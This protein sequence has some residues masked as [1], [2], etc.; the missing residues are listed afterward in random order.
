MEIGRRIRE[1]REA[2]NISQKELAE[3]IS[4]DPSQYSKIER[5]KVMPTLNQTMEIS[6]IF[7]I[8]VDSLIHNKFYSESYDEK[9][10]NPGIVAESISS[11][12][13]KSIPLLPLDAFAG[14]GGSNVD[15]VDFAQIEERYDVP[16]FYNIKVDFMINV[17]GSS[18]Y[19]KYSSGDVVACR[20]VDDLLFVQWNKIYVLDTISQG[21]I[22]KRLKKSNIKENVICKSDNSE[23]DDFEVPMSDIRNIALVVGSVRLE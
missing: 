12:G 5:G 4:M 21:V 11:Y 8:S 19:P 9:V 13:T 14:A 10:D 2:R 6:S 1:V 20:M 18:M 7:N 23:Y 16:L 17:R 15:G 3:K 22:M